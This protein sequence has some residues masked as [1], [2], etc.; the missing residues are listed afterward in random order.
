MSARQVERERETEADD[1]ERGFREEEW[2]KL[3]PIA[4]AKIKFLA[5]SPPPVAASH[6][7]DV[8]SGAPAEASMALSLKEEMQKAVCFRALHA[9]ESSC[10]MPLAAWEPWI[11]EDARTRMYSGRCTASMCKHCMPPQPRCKT[12]L[13]SNPHAS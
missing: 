6:S 9:E 3:S 5:R 12:T 13:S 11:G 4:Q 10:T 1:E 2:G 8:R 7:F